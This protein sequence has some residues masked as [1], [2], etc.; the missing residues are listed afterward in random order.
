[1]GRT[2][3]LA[4]L[5]CSLKW[6]AAMAGPDGSAAS[7][8]AAFG[9]KASGDRLVS[10]LDGATVA[11][12]GG[13]LSG[14]E[15]PPISRCTLIGDAPVSWWRTTFKAI[16]PGTNTVRLPLNALF[17]L[18]NPAA[19]GGGYGPGAY[20]SQVKQAIANAT[21]A[22]LY[23]IIDL[24]W[25]APNGYCAIGQPGFP[26]ADHAFEFWKEMADL[27]GHQSN[28]IFELFN[29]PYGD[30]LDRNCCSINAQSQLMVNGGSE[31]Q[32]VQQNNAAGNAGV[33]TKIAY[34]VAG[35]RA[36]L[37]TI[38][39]EGATN[40]VLG[41]SWWWDG[42]IDLWQA[43][44]NTADSNPDPLHNFGASMHA[45]GYKRGL[46]P[47]LSVLAA[48][49]PVVVTEFIGAVGSLGTEAQVRG[50]GVNG[51]LGWGAN[52]WGGKLDLSRTGW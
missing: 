5:A 24:H 30:G 39:G 9:V 6:H 37:Q 13:N 29:E 20:Q 4:L 32:L 17:W 36:L 50:V 16:H 49:Y 15:S 18:G 42:Q 48:G 52:D 19:C 47:L 45:Y 23:V 2:L 27:Y 1:M 21:A 46:G 14:C 41:S 12:I 3:A 31:Y 35:E 40:L 8:S 38:R 7:S 11:L 51:L 28:V 34:Q 26:D 10:T 25:T 33:T 22:G 44:W 43:L